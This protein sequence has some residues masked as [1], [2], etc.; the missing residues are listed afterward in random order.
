MFF[1]GCILSVKLADASNQE[2]HPLELSSD[3]SIKYQGVSFDGC[4]EN[5]RKTI[6]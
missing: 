6:L 3:T 5:V 4:F 2:L 1:A